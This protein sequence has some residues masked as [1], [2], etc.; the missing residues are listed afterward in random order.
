[1]LT[2]IRK[3]KTKRNQSLAKERESFSQP[4]AFCILFAFDLHQTKP[5]I[6]EFV[7]LSS[8]VYNSSLSLNRKSTLV[9]A[10]DPSLIKD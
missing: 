4:F 2:C 7:N 3:L 9:L 10:W 6:T 1:M 8:P 5:I